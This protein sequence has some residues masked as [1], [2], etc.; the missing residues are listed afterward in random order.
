MAA[1]RGGG[2]WK[3]NQTDRPDRR[4]PRVQCDYTSEGMWGCV[5]RQVIA[6]G[7]QTICH[8]SN[9]ARMIFEYPRH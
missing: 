1:A 2:L 3:S 9:S 4:V 6:D 7:F 8:A 5:N